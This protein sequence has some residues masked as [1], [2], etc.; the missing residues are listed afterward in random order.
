MFVSELLAGHRREIGTLEGNVCP[1][2]LEAGSLHHRLVPGPA[3][4]PLLSAR[5]SGSRRPPRTGTEVLAAK[6]PTL[7]Q[8]LDRAVERGLPYLTLDG[9]LISLGP[10]RGQE[11]Q[12]EG[13]GD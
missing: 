7:H 6:A 13:Q 2:L 12:Q 1:D 8:A 5:G 4:P 10:V 3:G 9:T 11:D